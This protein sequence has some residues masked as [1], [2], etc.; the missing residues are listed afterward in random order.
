MTSPRQHYVKWQERHDEVN[1]T[2]TNTHVGWVA[3]VI[4]FANELEGNCSDNLVRGHAR[5]ARRRAAEFKNA[6]RDAAN[7]YEK[8]INAWHRVGGALQMHLMNEGDR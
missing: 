5:D 2:V 6:R 1:S 3:A 7:I 4:E 8:F